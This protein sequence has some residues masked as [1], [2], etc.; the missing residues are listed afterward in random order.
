MLM[1]FTC[2]LHNV[3]ETDIEIFKF[4]RKGGFH[5]EEETIWH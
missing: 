4:I 1:I 2:D 3:D 5:V